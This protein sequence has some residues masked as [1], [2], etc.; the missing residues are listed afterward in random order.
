MTYIG[1]DKFEHTLENG[2]E[3]ILTL[4]DIET[5][6]MLYTSEVTINLKDYDPEDG[7]IE[8]VDD[9]GHDVEVSVINYTPKGDE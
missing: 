9:K 5:I 2:N 7:Y 4:V 3:V 6:A 1:S 8:V